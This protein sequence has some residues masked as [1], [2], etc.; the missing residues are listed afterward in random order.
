[1]KY[2]KDNPTTQ[3]RV[4]TEIEKSEDGEIVFLRSTSQEVSPR[5]NRKLTQ[6]R[7]SVKPD[8]TII[9]SDT[10]SLYEAPLFRPSGIMKLPKGADKYAQTEDAVLADTLRNA[11]D[12]LTASRVPDDAW[13]EEVY[14]LIARTQRRLPMQTM[15]HDGFSAGWA[16]G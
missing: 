11:Y 3:V 4:I 8:N 10:L 12:T 15:G 7:L 16:R 2:L 14:K 1:M 13:A 6:L 5:P 9:A